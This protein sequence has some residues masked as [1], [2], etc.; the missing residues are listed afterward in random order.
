MNRFKHCL[1][2][3]AVFCAVGCHHDK[4]PVEEP[5]D[6][7]ATA[8]EVVAVDYTVAENLVILYKEADSLTKIGEVDPYKMQLFVDNSTEYAK[9]NPSDT[10]SPH[11]LL[12][13]GIFQMEIAGS[14]PSEEIRKKLWFKSIDIFNEVILQFPRYKNLPYCYFYKGQ[15]YENL[16]RISD[17]ENEYRELVHRYPDSQLGKS[18]E[19]YVKAHGFEKSAD[20]L[21]KDIRK[22]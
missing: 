20:E 10:V 6:T 14:N 4:S 8:S 11:L 9:N 2:I 17:A 16:N 22:K 3:A 19:A 15:I 5:A 18:L 7:T 12:Y 1:A 21:W 13:A